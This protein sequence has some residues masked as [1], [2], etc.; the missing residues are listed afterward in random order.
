M[1]H[2]FL[3]VFWADFHCLS[4]KKY[5]LYIFFP[6]LFH[7]NTTEKSKDRPNGLLYSEEVI[8]SG[9]LFGG[10]ILT[11]KKWLNVVLELLS[12]TDLRFG[13]S[14]SVQY[15]HCYIVGDVEV[16]AENQKLSRRYFLKE[17]QLW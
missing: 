11:E 14:K 13:K 8:E 10:T 15:G 3:L 2:I 7:H 4:N 6:V 1:L 16:T 9:Q 17:I 5:L 12:Q